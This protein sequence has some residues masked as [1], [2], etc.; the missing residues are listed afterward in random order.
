MLYNPPADLSTGE[1][2]SVALTF[3][4]NAWTNEVS[5]LADTRAFQDRAPGRF[6]GIVHWRQKAL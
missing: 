6:E 2:H 3:L 1:T 4:F 5:A